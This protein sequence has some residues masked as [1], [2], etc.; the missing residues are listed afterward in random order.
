MHIEIK[1]KSAFYIDVDVEE[2]SNSGHVLHYE[3][4]S[5]NKLAEGHT[6]TTCQ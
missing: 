6:S 5:D 2:G 3:D 1:I 4:S